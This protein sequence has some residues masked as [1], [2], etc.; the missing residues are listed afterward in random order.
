[1]HRPP[2]EVAFRATARP[3]AK[4]ALVGGP[5]RR[6]ATHSVSMLKAVASC[7]SPTS[8]SH[9]K[10]CMPAITPKDTAQGSLGI[11]V[12]HLNR[13]PYQFVPFRASIQSLCTS[14][15]PRSLIFCLVFFS[16]CSAYVVKIIGFNLYLQLNF[17]TNIP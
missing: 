9:T 14:Y 8:E 12:D 4:A 15:C 5:R 3:L 17:D 1:M 2:N 7:L 16:I 6:T 13:L 11:Y 10:P